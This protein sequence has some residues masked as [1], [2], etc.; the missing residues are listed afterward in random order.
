MTK[1]RC[2]ATD[3][4]ILDV[5]LEACRCVMEEKRQ[6]GIATKWIFAGEPAPPGIMSVELMDRTVDR[7]RTAVEMAS[8]RQG[9]DPEILREA[10]A[11]CRGV[12]AQ[13]Q[14]VE[15]LGHELLAGR[16]VPPEPPEAE[17]SQ[18]RQH[19][20]RALTLAGDR[21]TAPPSPRPISRRRRHP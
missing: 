13:D 1:N 7:A 2:N 16:E 3:T 9:D 4:E 10:L 17:T 12:L 19:A 11:A 21:F 8:G 5:A 14:W 20:A 15:D 6:C 18:I